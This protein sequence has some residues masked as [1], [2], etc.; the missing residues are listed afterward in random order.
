[1][2]ITYFTVTIS[3]TQ[4]SGKYFRMVSASGSLGGGSLSGGSSGGGLSLDPIC[5]LP[6]SSLL[7]ARSNSPR[8]PMKLQWKK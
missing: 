1:M 5:N 8:G 3:Q 6:E 7:N 2:E 4:V